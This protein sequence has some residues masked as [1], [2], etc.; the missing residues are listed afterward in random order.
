M[1]LDLKQSYIILEQC[2]EQFFFIFYCNQVF[3]CC[4]LCLPGT[5]QMMMFRFDKQQT[6]SY[7]FPIESII[8]ELSGFPIIYAYVEFL[9]PF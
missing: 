7:S 9:V 4:I 3:L 8:R 5:S 1:Q 2:A 6:R